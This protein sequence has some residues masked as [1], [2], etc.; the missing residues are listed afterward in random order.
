V[1]QEN[2]F[3]YP[4]PQSVLEQ[5]AHLEQE[6][7]FDY[8]ESQPGHVEQVQNEST[9]LL[10]NAEEVEL[11]RSLR[12]RRPPIPSNNGV[13]F[14]ESDFDVGPKDDP[15]SFSQAISGDHS[16]LCL[17]AMKEE[18]ESMA[19]NQV[20]NLVNLPKGAVAI[21]CKW[22]YKTKKDTSS[23]VKRYK[24]RLLAK[25]YTQKQGRDYHETISPVSNKK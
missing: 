19:K 21:G 16:T 8:L 25:G 20:C 15:K 12:I 5:P 13:Y 9:Q 6:N 18:M 1:E 14:Q 4:E 24:A 3:D 11:R 23:N 22:V 10:Q 17:N 7:Q 2:Q